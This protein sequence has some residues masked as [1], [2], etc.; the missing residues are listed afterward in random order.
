MDAAGN[1]EAS[2]VDL[3]A[4]HAAYRQRVA[5]LAAQGA[6]VANDGKSVWT[7]WKSPA[8]EACIMGVGT[9]TFLTTT[10]C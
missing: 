8:C 5:E 9:E 4:P 7:T 10:K 1:R 6:H 3:V 2:A